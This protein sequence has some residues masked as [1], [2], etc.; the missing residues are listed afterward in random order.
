[1]TFNDVWPWAIVAVAVVVVVGFVRRKGNA[2]KA[3]TAV[4]KVSSTFSERFPTWAYTHAQQLLDS[5]PGIAR[6][7]AERQKLL[8][9]LAGAHTIYLGFTLPR[10]VIEL[11]GGSDRLATAMVSW[12]NDAKSF[13]LVAS[14]FIRPR[15]E[16][17]DYEDDLVSSLKAF[18]KSDKP[19]EPISVYLAQV[20]MN[21]LDYAE[22]D[23]TVMAALYD[24]FF[25]LQDEQLAW[26]REEVLA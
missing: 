12:P 3:M 1:M 20:T 8:D 4:E 10:E 7:T 24:A 23:G 5:L 22:F 9:C 21:W 6:G 17:K 16:K 2:P 14:E 26:L 11:I 18:H 13:Y 25:R 15:L 19:Y